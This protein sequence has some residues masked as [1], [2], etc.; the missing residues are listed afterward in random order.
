MQTAT[1]RRA[2][3]TKRGLC[4]VGIVGKI[5]I[6][7][8]SIVLSSQTNRPTCN[9]TF[10]AKLTLPGDERQLCAHRRTPTPTTCLKIPTHAPTN[11]I[12]RVL[13]HPPPHLL[14]Y[15]LV[16]LQ[17]PSIIL[18]NARPPQLRPVQDVHLSQCL[19]IFPS[20]TRHIHCKKNSG[21]HPTFR[22]PPPCRSLI[23]PLIDF[24]CLAV[25]KYAPSMTRTDCPPHS[26]RSPTSF[27]CAGRSIAFPFAS[28]TDG[29][30]HLGAVCRIQAETYFI[31]CWELRANPPPGSHLPPRWLETPY[32]YI[33]KHGIRNKA[34]GGTTGIGL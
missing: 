21:R 34:G 5:D 31:V 17:T 3:S 26:F 25:S 30:R 23:P 15:R 24:A 11:S 19:F 2:S 6:Y 8:V 14:A 33:Q 22:P 13:N 28:A 32:Q 27:P 9:L 4:M 7:I 18:I 29:P 1:L 12:G 16:S 20:V 10:H